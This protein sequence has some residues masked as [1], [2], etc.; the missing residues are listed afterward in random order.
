VPRDPRNRARVLLWRLR[1]KTAD[2]IAAKLGVSTQTVYYH[3]HRL[4]DDGE[5]ENGFRHY[6]PRAS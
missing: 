1:G 5:L 2:E 4:E 3:L 6:R